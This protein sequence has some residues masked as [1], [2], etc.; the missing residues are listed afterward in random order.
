MEVVRQATLRR[1]VAR[2]GT[3]TVGLTA[4]ALIMAAVAVREALG[5]H[6]RAVLAGIPIAAEQNVPPVAII[7]AVIAG[8]G[9]VLVGLS[10]L[11]A[12]AGMRV[13]ARDRR[14]PDPLPPALRRARAG[15]LTPLGPSAVRMLD[16]HAPP[17]GML[18]DEADT[19]A[20]AGA[21]VSRY[22]SRRTTRGSRSPPRSRR[23]GGRPGL[24][25]G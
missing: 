13:L 23:C 18:P 20:A 4:V 25:R 19:D 17:A 2:A 24:P 21:C 14:I 3:I 7:L 8:A 11:H 15:M 22:S 9:A 6:A 5:E 10:A 16:D 12:A 1:R